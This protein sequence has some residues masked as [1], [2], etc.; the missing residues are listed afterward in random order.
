MRYG[1][2]ILFCILFTLFPTFAAAD[3]FP[4]QAAYPLEIPENATGTMVTM[5]QNNASIQLD[6]LSVVLYLNGGEGENRWNQTI[7]VLEFKNVYPAATMTSTRTYSLP[8]YLK[9]G[10]YDLYSK[11]Y[12][13]AFKQETGEEIRWRGNLTIVPSD[14]TGSGIDLVAG[15]LI[16]PALIA[17]GESFSLLGVF[18]NAGDI[19]AE[20]EVL[21]LVTLVPVTGIP[22]ETELYL[23]KNGKFPGYGSGSF[24]DSILV[25]DF[26]TPGEY[27]LVMEI[28]PQDTI[29]ELSET[30]NRWKSSVPITVLPAHTNKD[31]GS[32]AFG[33]RISV[34]GSVVVAGK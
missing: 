33:P 8:S 4:V 28:D 13:R 14:I 17:A 29:S 7:D 1:Y 5:V 19:A 27:Y 12:G 31:T 25:P 32:S 24:S 11:A 16:A 34:S 15:G 23:W 20:T 30:N 18:A 22:E 3:I 10:K 9:P 6:T 26:V 21:V 2:F